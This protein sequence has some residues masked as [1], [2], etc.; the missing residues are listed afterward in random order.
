MKSMFSNYN[1]MKLD[2][3]NRKKFE[4]LKYVDI[5]TLLI[6]QCVKE[7]ITVKI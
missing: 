5:N 6:K 4:K 2:I 3:N 7:E 1:E